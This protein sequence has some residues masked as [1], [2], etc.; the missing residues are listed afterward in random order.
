M[1]TKTGFTKAERKVLARLARKGGHARA[2]SMSPEERSQSARLASRARWA[3]VRGQQAQQCEHTQW[4]S[5][6]PSAT[7]ED[8]TK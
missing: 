2:L 1:K 7:Q 6:R 4:P 8:N 5:E 3:H